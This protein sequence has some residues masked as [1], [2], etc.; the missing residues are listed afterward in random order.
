MTT[1]TKNLEVNGKKIK[2]V[3]RY[4]EGVIVRTTINGEKFLSNLEIMKDLT[5]N[6]VGKKLFIDF[7]LQRSMDR[8]YIKWVSKQ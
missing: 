5:I 6:D 7:F 3:S 4:C 8:A 1:K 2:I